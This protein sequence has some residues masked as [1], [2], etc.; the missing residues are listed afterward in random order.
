MFLNKSEIVADAAP[1]FP[2][3]QQTFRFSELAPRMNPMRLNP[4]ELRTLGRRVATEKP[5]AA[6]LA[7]DLPIV[8]PHPAANLAADVPRVMVSDHQ[9]GRLTLRKVG[10]CSSAETAS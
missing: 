7:L 2:G 3:R 9:Q 6:P 8:G 5:A 1:Q 10:R 4:T